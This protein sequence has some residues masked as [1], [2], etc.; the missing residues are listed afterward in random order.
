MISPTACAGESGSSRSRIVAVVGMHRSGTSAMTRALGY[1]GASLGDDFIETMPEVNAKGF[2][3]DATLNAVNI[4]LLRALGIDW[5]T[6]RAIPMGR[7]DD[8]ALRPILERAVAIL[9]EKT[10][11]AQFFAFKD[12]RTSIL[13]PFWKRAF[14][15]AGVEPSYLIALRHPASVADSLRA[16]NGFDLTKSAILWLR[17]TVRSLRETHGAQ[18]VLVDYDMLMDRPIEELRRIAADLRLG[19]PTP[20]AE[21]EF[22]SRFLAQELRH[23]RYDE[24]AATLTP[25]ASLYAVL[26]RVAGGELDLEHPLVGEQLDAADRFLAEVEPLTAYMDALERAATLGGAA[27]EVEF[28][29]LSTL[30]ASFAVA[31]DREPAVAPAPSPLRAPARTT[32]LDKLL[33]RGE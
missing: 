7:F 24:S 27:H 23:S 4:A 29:W 30:R 17:Y 25:A 11:N 15:L 6:N 16:R 32:W 26:R 10:H 21:A 3:E 8:A 19:V 2:W 1:A 20:A 22:A 13:L 12:P 33:G 14:S 28:P 31:V 18:R 5:L 9:R